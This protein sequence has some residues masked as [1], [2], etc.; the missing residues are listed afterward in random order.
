MAHVRS[1]GWV[2]EGD[3]LEPGPD[4]TPPKLISGVEALYPE[5]AQALKLRGRV[6][7]EMTISERGEPSDFRV[8]ESAGET[9]DDAVLA[10]VR[11]WRFA[12]AEK[13]GAKV[14]TRFRVQQTFAGRRALGARNGLS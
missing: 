5:S 13:N 14:R 4:V 11:T 9:L 1:L 7:V 8:V 12:P 10:A 6:T 3:F 2:H